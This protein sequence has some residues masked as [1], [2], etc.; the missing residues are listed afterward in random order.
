MSH[1]EHCHS[2]LHRKF[3]QVKRVGIV[4][5]ILVV[6]HLLFHLV[7]FLILP[8]VFVAL[9]GHAAEAPAVAVSEE[10]SDE[11]SPLSISPI[12]TI[13]PADFFLTPSIV[14]S[15]PASLYPL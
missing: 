1:C 12:P 11:E 6:L 7:E 2:K 8:T 9:G 4:G 3:F 14:D 13:L 15:A 10:L 5:A